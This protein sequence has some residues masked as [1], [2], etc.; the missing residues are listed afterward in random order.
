[1]T[2]IPKITKAGQDSPTHV[3]RSQARGDGA[4]FGSQLLRLIVLL[5]CD[6]LLTAPLIYLFFFFF[7]RL[8]IGFNVKYLDVPVLPQIHFLRKSFLAMPRGMW[9]LSAPTRD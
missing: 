3:C 2:L 9:D 8:G 4:E 7:E 5:G 6:F 1:M